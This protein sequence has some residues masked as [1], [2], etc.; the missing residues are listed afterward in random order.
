MRLWELKLALLSQNKMKRKFKI[1]LKLLKIV[2]ASKHNKF[3]M[4][5]CQL[6]IQK[7]KMIE[8]Q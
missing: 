1:M 3:Q 6:M 2:M 5:I 7:V 4:E 8:Q